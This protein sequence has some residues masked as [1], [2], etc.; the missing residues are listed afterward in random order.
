MRI[1]AVDSSSKYW[2]IVLLILVSAAD[3]ITTYLCV[4]KYGLIGEANPIYRWIIAE[5]WNLAVFLK[6]FIFTTAIA[7][8]LLQLD[9]KTARAVVVVLSLV[10]IN[11]L[12]TYLVL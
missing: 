2:Y 11:N 9:T 6:M 7:I 10:V 3:V 1:E 5:S 8:L 12:I 4:G